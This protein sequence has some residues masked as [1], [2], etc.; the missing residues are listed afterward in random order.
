[1]ITY[2]DVFY[3]SCLRVGVHVGVYTVAKVLLS[4][5]QVAVVWYQGN[6]RGRKYMRKG[7]PMGSNCRLMTNVSLTL[8]NY[9][10]SHR[11]STH[12]YRA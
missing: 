11:F 10:L 2:L 8:W 4:I 12:T 1:M 3:F 9:G 7:D 5:S 6:G